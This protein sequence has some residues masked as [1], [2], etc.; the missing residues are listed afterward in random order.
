MQTIPQTSFKILGIDPGTLITGFGVIRF[1][2]NQFQV[3]DYGVIRPPKN[4]TLN[5]RYV[6]I[7]HGINELWIK[8]NLMQCL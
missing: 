4:K 3:L 1:F 2:S 6:A 8:T 5:E 7:F